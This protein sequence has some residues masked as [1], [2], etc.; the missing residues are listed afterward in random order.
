MA[1]TILGL[2]L[3]VG[4]GVCLVLAVV[5]LRNYLKSKSWPT[6]EGTILT[7]EVVKTEVEDSI[8]DY[9]KA[10]VT[11]TYS[12]ADGQHYENAAVAA[13]TPVAVWTM[14]ENKA[15]EWVQSNPS[16]TKIA[17]CYDP[18]DPQDSALAGNFE[19]KNKSW[20]YLAGGTFLLVC[21]ALILLWRAD[22]WL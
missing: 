14:R 21:G 9:W 7:S 16:G 12:V 5:E 6:T 20:R 19:D 10:T 22:V 8:V 1:W 11:F 15:Q 4:G 3:L 2:I 18:T 17:V 13:W